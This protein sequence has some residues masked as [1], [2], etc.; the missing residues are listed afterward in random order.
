MPQNPASV[1]TQVVYFFPGLQPLTDAFDGFILQPVLGWNQINNGAGWTIASWNCCRQRNAIH[2]PLVAVSAGNNLYGYV[3]GTGCNA[4]TG[5]CT[6]WQVFTSAAGGG[7]TTLNT[8]AY[9][10]VLNW[11][12][13]GVLEAYNITSCDQYPPNQTVTY[14]NVTTRNINGNSTQPGWGTSD[15]ARSPSCSVSATSTSSTAT[16]TWCIPHWNCSSSCGQT[17]TDTC[18]GTQTCPACGCPEGYTDCG[19]SCVLP[20]QECP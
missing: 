2:S 16:I 1:G 4:Q 7:Q 20:P 15:P 18:G 3:W 5:V 14:S 11:N 6:G 9:G 12:F 17:I 10:D 19:G 13:S 8:D